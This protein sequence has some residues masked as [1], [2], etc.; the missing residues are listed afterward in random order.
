MSLTIPPCDRGWCAQPGGHDG[1]HVRQ[2]GD[3]SVPT[4]NTADRI[5]VSV[6]CGNGEHD[7]L[8]VLTLLST[9]GVPLSTVRLDWLANLRLVDLLAGAANRFA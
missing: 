7:P 4:H 2:L 9:L 3:V 6:E 8:P 1:N 5:A